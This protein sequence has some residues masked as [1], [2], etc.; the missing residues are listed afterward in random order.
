[1]N[2][3]IAVSIIIVGGFLALLFVYKLVSAVTNVGKK[4]IDAG[5][6]KTKEVAK[7][8]S[9]SIEKNREKQL[10]RKLKEAVSDE[11]IRELTRRAMRN[12]I[13]PSQ[14]DIC[15][16]CS[17]VGCSLCVNTGWISKNF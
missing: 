13:D 6:H 10:K 15:D 8:I 2:E 3:L 11:I 16:N 7:V 1:M 17:G 14:Y 9:T 12:E 4:G 5:V